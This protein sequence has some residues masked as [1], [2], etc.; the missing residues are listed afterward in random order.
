MLIDFIFPN[1]CL[2]CNDII[3]KTD[4]I[5]MICEDQLSFSNM[6][7]HSNNR[8]QERT[9]LLFPCENSYALLA[10]EKND[11]SQKILHLLKYGHKESI[12]KILAQWTTERLTLQDPRPDIIISVPLHPK[13]QK[14]RGYNQLHLFCNELA[15][16]Y[17]IPVD[18]NFIIRNYHT[19]EQARKDKIHRNETASIFSV[20]EIMDAAHILL[21]DDVYTTGNTLSTIAWEILKSNPQHKISILVMAMDV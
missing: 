19:A 11:L 1:R 20:T 8:L 13:K 4:L 12:G 5:C 3:S 18:H 6:D 14:K 9:R 2:E 16:H 10:Y 21:I 17:N 7:Y 15:Q